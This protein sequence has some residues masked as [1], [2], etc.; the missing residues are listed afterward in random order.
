MTCKH[1]SRMRSEAFSISCTM[2]PPLVQRQPR[3]RPLMGSGPPFPRTQ[4]RGKLDYVTPP[5][6]SIFIAARPVG[7]LR[8]HI[9]CQVRGSFLAGANPEYEHV[10]TGWV[11]FPL[12]SMSNQPIAHALDGAR[13]RTEGRS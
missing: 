7:P 4:R 8:G 1:A 3:R 11:D 5:R 10:T 2:S 9:L 12:V 13:S 6:S